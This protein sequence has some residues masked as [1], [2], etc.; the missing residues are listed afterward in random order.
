MKLPVGGEH[1]MIRNKFSG[2]FWQWYLPAIL[3]FL[4]GGFHTYTAALT[5]VLVAA[6]LIRH[7]CTGTPFRIVINLSTAAVCTIVLGYWVTLL[8]AADR[9]MAV[10]G[11]LRSFPILLLALLQMQGIEKTPLWTRIPHCGA[12]MTLLSCGLYIFPGMRDFVTVNGRLSGFLQYPNTFAAFLLV[13]VAVQGTKKH[14]HADWILDAILVLGIILSGSRTGL[15]ILILLLFGISLLRSKLHPAAAVAVA[16]GMLLI[17]SFGVLSGDRITVLGRDL[18]SLFVRILY[19]KDALPVILRH[20][21]GLGYLGYRA[22][23][24]TFQTS[25]YTV[26]FVHS[27]LLQILLDVGWIPAFLLAAAIIKTLC[28]PGTDPTAR[29]VLLVLS[30]HAL[31]DFDLQFFLFWVILLLCLDF[32]TGKVYCLRIPKG[33]G[34]AIMVPILALC[35]WLGA[36]DWCYQTGNT[37]LALK[38]TPFHT[39]ALAAAMKTADDPEALDQLAD[40]VLALNPTQALAYSAKANAA[41]ARGQI[42]EMM[43]YKETAIRLTPY[44]TEEYCDYI[45]KLYSVL[46]IYVRS[47]DQESAV[48]CLNKLLEIPE[49][50]QEVTAGTDPLAFQTGNNSEVVLPEQ[51]QRLLTELAKA[52]PNR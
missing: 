24:T 7:C 41:Y 45:E 14:H 2:S 29:M 12:A 32:E 25:R 47:G 49:W 34:F 17:C 35:L 30:A 5:A 4:A 27:G 19:Y 36:G 52:N 3:P 42:P 20:P 16:G 40:K 43:Q 1:N 6:P 11:I 9:G 51:Y 13:C 23:E 44:T 39:D 8:W 28:A 18:G 15:L 50:M 37:T 22:L 10:F 21:F 46:E 48:Y 38:I 31:V 33:P 26:L